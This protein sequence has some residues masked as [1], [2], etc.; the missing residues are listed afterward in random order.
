MIAIS[1]FAALSSDVNGGVRLHETSAV[2]WVS[3]PQE[4]LRHTANDSRSAL[5]STF[6]AVQ[7]E[8]SLD[9]GS[10]ATAGFILLGIAASC[11]AS[12][13]SIFPVR[14]LLSSGGLRRFLN[15]LAT[16]YQAKRWT[17]QLYQ[18]WSEN[19]W[20][21]IVG[22]KIVVP[23]IVYLLFL[24]LVVVVMSFSAGAFLEFPH[25]RLRTF[26]CSGTVPCS[27]IRP[28]PAHSGLATDRLH[29]CHPVE[30]MSSV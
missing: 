27:A 1:G 24:G 7:V 8:N 11:S 18:A 25:S 21:K 30:L 17:T 12:S 4:N 15:E 20:S 28:G 19:R 16:A 9:L 14:R 29:G 13:G 10:I 6:I 22:G 2:A 26:R 23:A 5:P 3:A